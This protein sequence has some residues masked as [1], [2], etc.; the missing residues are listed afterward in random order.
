MSV[1]VVFLRPLGLRLGPSN[2][3]ST[4]GT[5]PE[6]WKKVNDADPKRFEQLQHDFIQTNLYD[7]VAATLEKSGI[8]VNKRSKA[9]K[10][11]V[12]S[13]AVQHGSGAASKIISQAFKQAGGN[14]A[15]DDQVIPLIYNIRSGKFGSSTPEVQAS[16]QNR[17]A[18]ES[19]TALAQLSAEKNIT[20]NTNAAEI[21][22][23]RKQGMSD[24]EANT[25]AAMSGAN[26]QKT[27]NKSSQSPSTDTSKLASAFNKKQPV[28]KSTESDK[29]PVQ[30][31]SSTT[32]INTSASSGF[33]I[34]AIRYSAGV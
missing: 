31:A 23:L 16:V 20:A 15:S 1:I 26:T 28:T 17:F 11:V 32:V 2:T 33:N 5:F 30:I 8:D 7:P 25:L 10:D 9:F 27:E 24:T 19:K 12:W 22:N 6:A 3:G 14:S 13:T 29:Q 21:D 18:S 4:K 34:D